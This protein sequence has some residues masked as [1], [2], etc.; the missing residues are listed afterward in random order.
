MPKEVFGREYQ[1]LERSDLLTFEEIECL[2]RVFVRLGV[3]KVRITGGEP[4]IRRNIERLIRMVADVGDIDVALTTNGSLLAGKARDLKDA[5]LSRVTV[6]ID[7]LDDCTFRAMNDV[8]YPVQR[9]LD[10]IEAVAELGLPVKINCVVKR[11]LNEDT[12]LDLARGFKGTDHIVRF[13][14]YMDVGT[15]N[16]WRMEDVVPAHEIV[17]LISEHMPLEPIEPN[18]RSEVAKRYRY[19]D[20][21]GEIGF[22]ASV[23]EPFCGD[24]SRVRMSAEGMLYTCLFASVGHDLRAIVRGGADV[25]A[26]EEF[27]TG[28]WS[29]R[30]D[31]YSEIR[32]AHTVALPKVEMSYIGG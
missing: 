13:I 29:N 22:I 1:F 17:S 4:L 14:E 6:S 28:I 5:G 3:K 25:D 27:I 12:I 9:V 24:C 23:T 20:G 19:S 10:G 18:Y 32:S 16:G 2:V 8:N 15:T 26:I 21:G 7:S 30:E 11:G 31:R